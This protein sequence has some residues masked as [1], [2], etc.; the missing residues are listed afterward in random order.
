MNLDIEGLGD[1]AIMQNDWNNSLCRPE[2]LSIQINW[3]NS[4]SGFKKSK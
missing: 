4:V 3:A 1:Y 2:V